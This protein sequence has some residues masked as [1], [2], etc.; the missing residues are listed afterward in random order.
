[1]QLIHCLI[2][3]SDLTGYAKLAQ[4]K[5]EEELFQ[6][7]SDYY[8]FVGDT[9]A[10]AKGTV[11]KFMGDAAL[12][13]FPEASAD[14][15]VRALLALHTEGDRYL[16]SRGIPCRHHI[17]AHFGAVRLGLLGTRTEKRLDILGSEVNTLFL[18]KAPGFAL[19]AEA[20]RKL[21]KET[22]THFKKH[23]PPIT[24]IPVHQPHKD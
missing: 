16:S 13:A 18:L 12:M 19:T 24:Y 22:R 5:P 21:G 15:G 2:A 11:I 9:I 7:L 3:C 4:A 14:S 1:M 8:E 17:R 20:F 10:P 6:L 23:T